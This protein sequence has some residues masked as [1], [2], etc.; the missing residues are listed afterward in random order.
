MLVYTLLAWSFGWV[1]QGWTSLATIILILGSAQLFVLGIFG[2]Y[3]GRMYMETKRRPLFIVNEIAANGAVDA[4]PDP[5][6]HR[7]QALAAGP[8]HHG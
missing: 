2:E 1:V 3:L 6:R 5:R 8:I 7:G 4:L